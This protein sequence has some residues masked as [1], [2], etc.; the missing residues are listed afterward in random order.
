MVTVRPEV[1]ST[2]LFCLVG[3]EFFHLH[4][5]PWW[6][7]PISIIFCSALYATILW[8]ILGL[9]ELVR[10]KYAILSSTIVVLLHILIIGFCFSNIFLVL[11]F[12]RH[13][14]AFTLNFVKETSMQEATEFLSSFLF[15]LPTLFLL[16]ATIA[17]IG[18]EYYLGKRLKPLPFIPQNPKWR[19]CLIEF[20]VLML[21]HFVFFSL[22]YKANYERAY[23]LPIKRTSLWQIQQSALQFNENREDFLRCAATLKDYDETLTQAKDSVDFVLIIGESYDICR[24]SIYGC[25]LN[26][27]PNLKKRQ[28][29]GELIIFNNVR[30]CYNGTTSSF[31]TFMSC[32]NSEDEHEWWKKPLFP[33][34]LRKAG[35]NVVYFSNQFVRN[36]DLDMF[37]AS[38]GFLNHPQIEPYIFDVRNNHTS[39][40]DMG[41]ID[42]YVKRRDKVEKVG[43]NFVVFH[44]FGQHERAEKR[45]PKRFGS[46]NVENIKNVK[47]LFYEEASESQI[48]DVAKYLNATEYNDMVVENIIKLFENRNAIILYIADHGEEIYNYRD[49]KG[50]TDM[51]TDEDEAK[52]HQLDVPFVFYLSPQFQQSHP[53]LKEK[54]QN[55]KDKSFKLNLLSNVVFDILSVDSKFYD[56]DKDPLN[57]D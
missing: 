40:Y 14:D 32:S 29:N 46:F 10:R 11:T 18:F 45:Y 43:P 28:D 38:M 17:V 33:A 26:T 41:L 6:D 23:G 16:L 52:H 30:A 57:L 15:T 37:D 42:D 27:T 36:D 22:D 49:Q 19:I 8:V 24:S 12:R 1:W 13:W 21:A 3:Q 2:L 50:R 34:V 56:V 39:P 55:A 4:T 54:I 5:H 7:G 51:T 31:Q 9:L 48:S 47:N 44:L 35:Y 53:T 25:P 20:G